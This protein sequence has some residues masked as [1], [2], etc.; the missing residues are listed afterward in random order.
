M[1]SIPLSASSDSA[2][3]GRVHPM[4]I[5]LQDNITRPKMVSNGTI[6]YPLPQALLA[7]NS[8]TIDEPICFLSAMKHVEWRKPRLE[9]GILSL[10]THPSYLNHACKHKAIYGLN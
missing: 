2:G 5:R 1:I 4:R 6:H 3:P 8:S 7:L 10:L 9:P